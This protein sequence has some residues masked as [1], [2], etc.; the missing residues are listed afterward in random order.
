MCAFMVAGSSIH[1]AVDY[2]ITLPPGERVFVTDRILWKKYVA[3]EYRHAI[4]TAMQRR[5]DVRLLRQADV[6]FSDDG[7]GVLRIEEVSTS[8]VSFRWREQAQVTSLPYE[9]FQELLREYG[10]QRA[11]PEHQYS[12]WGARAR[13]IPSLMPPAVEISTKSQEIILC[14]L[15]HKRLYS[16]M[17]E[18]WQWIVLTQEYLANIWECLSG[19]EETMSVMTV[20]QAND[21]HERVMQ[22]RLAESR[23]LFP[24]GQWQPGEI[25]NWA[26]RLMETGEWWNDPAKRDKLEDDMRESQYTKEIV[27]KWH[28][29]LK[30]GELTAKELAVEVGCSP[31]TIYL[32]LKAFD[33]LPPK[34]AAVSSMGAAEENTQQ[35]PASSPSRKRKRSTAKQ[36]RA[37]AK[38]ADAPIAAPID[39]TAPEIAIAV[40]PVAPTPSA[41]SAPNGHGGELQL[42]QAQAA[43][44]WLRTMLG[45]L[46]V[47]GAQVSGSVSVRLN[48]SVD[49]PIGARK[50]GVA[51]D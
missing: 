51:T 36:T 3:K 29:R 15:L 50:E 4:L 6:L 20:A 26:L 28:E 27:C 33:L 9:R 32:R 18:M 46:Q 49:V 10:F 24:P 40:V 12:W 8:A 34:P 48:L 35:K 19:A 45:E 39:E 22:A 17:A 1:M 14:S 37:T 11:L 43:A 47:A 42:A 38:A 16:A 25:K 23:A 13:N 30:A 41:P 21:S 5:A 31:A 44:E 2:L 7:G